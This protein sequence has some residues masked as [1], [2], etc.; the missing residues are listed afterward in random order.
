M[1]H[2]ART[3]CWLAVSAGFFAS[4]A[5]AR[6]EGGCPVRF[7]WKAFD[8]AHTRTFYQTLTTNTKQ[9]MKVNGMTV[10]QIQDQIFYIQWIPQPKD[11]QGN[12]VVIEKV[13]GVKMDI[14]IGGNKIS[15]DSKAPDR[16]QGPDPM[17]DFFK[18]VLDLS[19]T[20]TLDKDLK[21]I[22]IDGNEEFM[23]KLSATNP[24]M[25]PLLK[26]ILSEDA[27]KKMTEPTLFAFPPSSAKSWKRESILD[28]GPIG[29]YKTDYS[30][31]RA[32]KNK[33]GQEKI[34]VKATMSYSLPT[35]KGKLSFTIEG[36]NMSA[37]DG[38]GYVLFNLRRGWFDF[39]TMNMTLEGTLGID[40]GGMKAQL[41]LK[42]EQAATV[43]TTAYNPLVGP[44][45]SEAELDEPDETHVSCGRRCRQRRFQMLRR[46]RSRC[47]R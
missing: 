15:Y 17:T 45:E 3:A 24:Q 28:L 47:R 46:L 25:E 11:D 31:T 2:W 16:P 40:I 37:K 19:L 4:P 5:A 39:Y 35:E 27:L 26:S 10:E 22:R 9:T 13:I 33:R 1:S 36:G 8:P 32:G 18:A 42:Q 34:E 12:W 30:F 20:F 23:K 41:E 7:E 21:V 44:P 43:T 38:S 6:A 14:D 29:S